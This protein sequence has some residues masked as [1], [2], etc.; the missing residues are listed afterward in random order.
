MNRGI[1][2]RTMF[3]RREDVE[4]FLEGLGEAC[5]R[6]E[7]EVH[8]YCVLTTHYHLLVRSPAGSLATAM[9]RVQTEYSRWFN[10]ARKRDGPLVRS[11]Y[12]SRPVESLRYRRMVVAYIDRNP[13][14]AGLVA[15]ASEHPYGSARFYAVAKEDGPSWLERTWIEE[16]VRAS[17]R[18]TTY[19]PAAY[20]QTFG[21]LPA[22]LAAIVEARWSSRVLEDPLDDL[23]DAAP[24]VVLD[25]MRRKARLAD[26]VPVGLPLVD[27]DSLER[28]VFEIS[29]ES[30]ADWR[31]GR[32]AGWTVVR[33]GLALQLCGS[34]LAETA[35]RLTLSKST[36]DVLIRQHALSL[37]TDEEY[38]RRSSRVARRALDAY[39]A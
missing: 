30:E 13:V 27:P 5:S 36:V 9:Q 21:R 20:E 7:L 28:A 8:A 6:G 12:R 18:S 24:P 23:V 38:G 17:T 3:E 10:R 11:R 35:E 15:R 16:T 2:R 32:R 14:A 22:A 4:V 25:W 33:A 31:I 19:S 26:G 39:G 1:A 37:L 29:S 34:S